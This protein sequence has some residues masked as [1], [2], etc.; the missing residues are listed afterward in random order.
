[1][2]KFFITTDENGNYKIEEKYIFSYTYGDGFSHRLLRI[3][4]LVEY[5][6][7]CSLQLESFMDVNTGNGIFISTI[8]T[9][10][11]K[12]LE[13]K[14]RKFIEKLKIEKSETTKDF[15]EGATDMPF[16]RFIY[17]DLSSNYL[18]FLYDN[19]NLGHI[20]ASNKIESERL[21]LQNDII[22]WTKKMY[23]SIKE[24]Y[25]EE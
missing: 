5:D 7:N 17:G 9:R 12:K 22:V 11:P 16:Y 2:D 24:S 25:N 14:L 3:N 20:K 8:E 23:S 13:A 19:Y 10:L 15:F 6:F 21:N 1:M 18:V 4:L